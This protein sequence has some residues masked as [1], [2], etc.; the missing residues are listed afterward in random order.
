MSK[1]QHTPPTNQQAPQSCFTHASRHEHAQNDSYD[2]TTACITCTCITCCHVRTSDGIC[3]Q[4]MEVDT[5]MTGV[6]P[7]G[8]I[9]TRPSQH[10]HVPQRPSYSHKPYIDLQLHGAVS[11]DNNA[12]KARS[13]KIHFP[14]PRANSKTIMAVTTII[15]AYRHRIEL[16]NNET[17]ASHAITLPLY[18]HVDKRRLYLRW[19]LQLHS[20]VLPRLYRHSGPLRSTALIAWCRR[21]SQEG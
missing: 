4:E 2:N 1:H 9:T 15:T 18:N 20:R 7:C 3:P 6:K 10:T 13:V 16:A 12:A 5:E 8:L 19:A 17:K 11:T 21:R 14:Q